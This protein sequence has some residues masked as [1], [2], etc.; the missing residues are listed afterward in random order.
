MM[1]GDT[2]DVY[3]AADVLLVLSVVDFPARR[4]RFLTFSGEAG[5]DYRSR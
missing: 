5:E 2:K 1:G 3:C 4:L